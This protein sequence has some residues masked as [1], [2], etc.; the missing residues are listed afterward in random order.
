MM[1]KFFSLVSTIDDF[2]KHMDKIN[3]Y[4]DITVGSY[5]GAQ[6]INFIN[7]KLDKLPSVEKLIMEYDLDVSK[8]KL[9]ECC[10]D[11]EKDPDNWKS[12]T[13]AI[14]STRLCNYAKFNSKEFK[15]NNIKQYAELMLT[16]SFSI[17]QKFLMVK[18]I[19]NIN[20]Q[21][22]T[23]TAGDPRFLKYLSAK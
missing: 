6:L 2:D 20:N 3:L 8:K 18:N 16:P 23:I 5:I 10:G 1:D 9:T 21:F 14:L 19:V 4:A 13:A 11:S 12:A 7:K 17:D 15:K 22:V